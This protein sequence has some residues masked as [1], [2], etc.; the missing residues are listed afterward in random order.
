MSDEPYYLPVPR[1]GDYRFKAVN[2][3][4]SESQI[5]NE[6]ID[7]VEEKNVEIKWKTGLKIKNPFQ[8][9]RKGHSIIFD[10]FSFLEVP[11]SPLFDLA[12]CSVWMLSMFGGRGSWSDTVLPFVVLEV[13]YRMVLSFSLFHKERRSWM[14]LLVFIPLIFMS[15]VL[16]VYNG[17]EDII[18]RVFDV[19]GLEYSEVMKYALGGFLMLWIFVVPYIWYCVL[20]LKK[21]LVCSDLTWEELLGGVLWHGR[22]ERTCSAMLTIML[23]A[24]L[25]GLSMNT[26]LCQIMCLTATPLTYWLLCRYNNVNTDKVWV[27][28]VGMAFFWYA[29]ILTGMWRLGMLLVSFGLVIYVGTRLY[30]NIK[31]N[32]LVNIVVLYLGI[33]L[34]S[35]SIGYNQYACI[36]YAKSGIY[37]LSPF[38]GILYITDSTRELYGLRD[39][40]GLL[41]EPEYEHIREGDRHPNGWTYIYVLQKDGYDRYYDVYNNR[42]VHESDIFPGLQREIRE[43]LENHFKWNS[44]YDDKGQI[45]VT[46]LLDGK[47]IAD[48]RISMYGNPFVNYNSERFIPD[49]SIT[50]S[51][52]EFFRNDSVKVYHGTKHSL[53]YAINIPDDTVSRYRIYVRLATDCVPSDS[54]LVELAGKVAALKE[55]KIPT[56]TKEKEDIQ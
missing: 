22:L 38:Q 46:E 28:V 2:D 52:G 24:F 36:N 5:L 23:V 31:N 25:T 6:V 12:I 40:Y 17:I 14:P 35:F 33:L 15:V 42:F 26:R 54:T 3:L 43:I 32:L 51:S 39:R 1:K 20:L 56:K 21:Q 29:Q 9:R 53:S 16:G 19:T 30:H 50:V 49:D 34:P 47:T 45:T 11:F 44:E 37:Y 55:L 18:G 7:A 48:V 10:F 4:T 13:L 8:G 41:V 27:L